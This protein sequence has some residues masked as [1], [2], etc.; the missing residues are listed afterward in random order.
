MDL[1]HDAPLFV[2]VSYK[3]CVFNYKYHVVAVVRP[4]SCLRPFL[5]ITLI[6]LYLCLV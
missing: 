4:Q 3:L 1:L 2:T 5:A 6:P